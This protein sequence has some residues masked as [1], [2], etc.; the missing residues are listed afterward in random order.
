MVNIDIW[1][2]GGIGSEGVEVGRD[3]S[4]ILFVY[5]YTAL[6]NLFTLPALLGVVPL[7]M[8]VHCGVVELHTPE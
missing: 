4:V 1:R 5:H 6:L 3:I 2:E 8:L 7:G